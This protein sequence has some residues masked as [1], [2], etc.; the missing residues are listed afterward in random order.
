MY[1]AQVKPITFRTTFSTTL[2][3]G[4]EEQVRI[5]GEV[6]D[7][8][9]TYSKDLFVISLNNTVDLGVTNLVKPV[10]VDTDA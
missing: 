1:V 9:W 5:L 10:T 8:S 2:K 4:I 6:V 7:H 3:V